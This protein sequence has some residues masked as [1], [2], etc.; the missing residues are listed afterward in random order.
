M[1]LP[2]VLRRYLEVCMCRD[3]YLSMGGCASVCLGT[4]AFAQDVR[5]IDPLCFCLYVHMCLFIICL[6]VPCLH[7]P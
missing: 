4:D 2:A 3:V 1:L 5:P 7:K 6:C